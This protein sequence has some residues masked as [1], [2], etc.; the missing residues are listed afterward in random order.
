MQTLIESVIFVLG[1]L[2]LGS[3]AGCVLSRR[4]A[5]LTVARP[6]RSMCLSCKT[7]LRWQDNVPLVSYLLLRGRCRY[8]G[9][10]IG[11]GDFFIEV[12]IG[13]VSLSVGFLCGFFPAWF[14]VMGFIFCLFTVLGVRPKG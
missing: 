13:G 2:S 6:S 1:G 10:P 9:A 7:P 4:R 11:R 12:G 5:G 3:Y 14:L 8:C